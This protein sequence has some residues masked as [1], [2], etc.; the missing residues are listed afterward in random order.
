MA[1]IQQQH[2]TG[3]AGWIGFASF[4]MA[5]SGIVHIIYGIGG[6]LGQDWYI[7]ANGTAWWFDSSTWGWSLI[8]GGILLLMAASLLLA[9]NMFG[10]IVGTILALASLFANVALFAAAPVWSTLAIMVDLVIIYA[11]I[12]HGSEMKQLQE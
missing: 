5:L 6:V 7:Y 12:A 4:M 10:R 3:W 2:I 11:V 8:A 9:G 1:S